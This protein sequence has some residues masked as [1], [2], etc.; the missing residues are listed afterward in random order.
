M[1]FHGTKKL[2]QMVSHDL[3]AWN[4]KI[5]LSMRFELRGLVNAWFNCR[6]KF[7]L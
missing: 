6:I 5:V 7:Y 1:N 3:W 2:F 4:R